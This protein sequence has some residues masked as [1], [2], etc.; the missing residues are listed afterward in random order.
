MVTAPASL[1][2]QGDIVTGAW[3]DTGASETM[4]VD[5]V[6]VRGAATLSLETAAAGECAWLLLSAAC[7]SDSFENL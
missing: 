3:W 4:A 5:H 7:I 2:W 6:T 1:G